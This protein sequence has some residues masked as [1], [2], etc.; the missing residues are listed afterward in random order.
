MIAKCNDNEYYYNCKGTV[1]IRENRQRRLRCFWSLEDL[2]KMVS[3]GNV[4]TIEARVEEAFR[5]D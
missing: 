3:E 2:V 1:I 5:L 4:K